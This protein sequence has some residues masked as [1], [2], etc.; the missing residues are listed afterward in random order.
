MSL[1]HFDYTFDY[2]LRGCTG[3]LLSLRFVDRDFVRVPSRALKNKDDTK[4]LSLFFSCLENLLIQGFRA[5]FFA[6]ETILR[7]MRLSIKGT[8]SIHSG[9]C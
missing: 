9:V 2:I 3:K 4:V 7:G 5:F 8:I 6:K 1:L